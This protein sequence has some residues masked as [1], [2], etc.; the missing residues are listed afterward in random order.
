MGT[1]IKHG[2]DNNAC[3]GG[4]N[5]AVAKGNTDVSKPQQIDYELLHMRAGNFGPRIGLLRQGIWK[6]IL[7]KLFTDILIVD[8][9][10]M[11]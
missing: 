8:V 3:G 2:Y 11:F 10:C 5:P 9:L 4:S 1:N 6:Q 7:P